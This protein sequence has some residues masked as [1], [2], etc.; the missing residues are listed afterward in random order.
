MVQL[1]TI[2]QSFVEHYNACRAY[3]WV[4][5]CCPSGND[6]YD[7]LWLVRF[8]VGVYICGAI[9]VVQDDK[10]LTQTACVGVCV[11]FVDCMGF[12]AR[13][14]CIGAGRCD[15]TDRLD[16]PDGDLISQGPSL[17]VVRLLIAPSEQSGSV[18]SA[19]SKLTDLGNLADGYVGRSRRVLW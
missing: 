10:V 1:S 2:V 11:A 19:F 9:G 8:V 17:A 12:R 3:R 13:L 15:L 4:I 14:D 18:P 5:V 16:G 6:G 7:F